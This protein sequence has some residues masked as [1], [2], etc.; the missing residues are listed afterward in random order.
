[1]V[2]GGRRWCRIGDG[3][4]LWTVDGF[5]EGGKEGASSH[6]TNHAGITASRLDST[7]RATGNSMPTVNADLSEAPRFHQP[8]PRLRFPASDRGSRLFCPRKRSTIDRR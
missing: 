1:M 8:I 3:T 2:V 6:R 4:G 7:C 5:E